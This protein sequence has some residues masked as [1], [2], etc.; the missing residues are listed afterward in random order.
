MAFFGRLMR[1]PFFS[2]ASAVSLALTLAAAASVSGCG[3]PGRWGHSPQY[4]PASGEQDA[5]ADTRDLNDGAQALL[6]FE[7]WKGAKVR[8]FMVVDERKPGPGGAAYVTGQLH[9]LNEINGCANKHDND[10]CRVT[11]KPTGHDTVHAIV[12]LSGEDDIG[13]LRVGTGTLLR[14][15]GVLSDQTDPDDGKLVIQ[16]SWYRQWPIGYY[17]KEGDLLQ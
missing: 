9:T 8:F 15:V 3:S 13:E 5:I 10:S 1:C 16:G 17:A 14:V 7:K 11:I 4:V 6:T 12:R 2:A